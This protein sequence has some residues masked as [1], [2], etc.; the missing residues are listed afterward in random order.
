MDDYF[1]VYILT[2]KWQ[3]VL[4]TGM[5]D[6]IRGRMSQHKDRVYTGFTKKYNCD[7]LVNFEKFDIASKNP[8]CMDLSP[9]ISAADPSLRSGS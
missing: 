1:F 9:L 7:Q 8:E 5:T 4:D 2:N 3:T 6:S